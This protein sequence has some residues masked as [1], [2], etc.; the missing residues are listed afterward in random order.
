V[1]VAEP[2]E[3]E[4]SLAE[5]TSPPPHRMAIAVFALAGLLIAGYLLLYKFQVLSNL[6]CG[7]GGCETVQASPWAV[8]VGVPVPAWGVAGYL[9][10]L[11]LALAG[12]QPR[13]ARSR[14]VSTLLLLSATIAFLFSMYLTAIEAFRIHAWCRWCVGSAVVATILFALSLLELPAVFGRRQS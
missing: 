5:Q 6:A 2:L 3:T 12:L 1:T 4:E 8:F 11:V 13:F 9:M 7:S 10:I 14:A